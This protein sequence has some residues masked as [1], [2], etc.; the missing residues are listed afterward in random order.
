VEFDWDEANV[1]HIAKHG[2]ETWEVEEAL[3]DPQA[4]PA[5][6]YNTQGERRY[7]VLELAKQDAFCSWSTPGE[8]IRFARF[9]RAMPAQYKNGATGRVEYDQSEGKRRARAHLV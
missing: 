4:L 8:V 5:D 3:E 2:I 7:G 6:A 9:T 1:E